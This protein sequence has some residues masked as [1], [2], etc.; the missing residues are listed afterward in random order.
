MSLATC[1]NRALSAVV[2]ATFLS[3]RAALGDVG[4]CLLF[5]GLSCGN[6]AFVYVFLPETKGRT[7]EAM[8][9]SFAGAPPSP[10]G[11]VELSAA[12]REMV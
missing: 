9:A 6:A 1:A 7:L 8:A 10:K 4:F 12:H 2:S 5:A 3:L 11:A